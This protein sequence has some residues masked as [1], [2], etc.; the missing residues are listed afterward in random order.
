MDKTMAQNIELKLKV[1]NFNI[2]LRLINENNIPFIKVIPQRDVYYK[3]NSGLLKLRIFDHKGELIY[4]VRNENTSNRI[5]NYEILNVKPEEAENFFGKL[6][7]T[8]TE[9]VK[10][11]NLYIHKNTR[12]HLDEVKELG[13]FI[14]LETVVNEGVETG[15]K[16]FDEVVKLLELDISNQIK[17]SYRNLLLNK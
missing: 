6:F 1:E 8:E 5:S 16:E 3:C 11:R 7:E 15:K 4:Y 10:T 14:E 12:I 17:S 2:V 13:N 9:V